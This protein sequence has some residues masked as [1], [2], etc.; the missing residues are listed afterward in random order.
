[1]SVENWKLEK[2]L[3]RCCLSEGTFQNLAE[4]VTNQGAEEIYSDMLIEGLDVNVSSSFLCL[5]RFL[6]GNHIGIL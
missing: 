1:M 5:D 3:C 6:H 4:P 2:D